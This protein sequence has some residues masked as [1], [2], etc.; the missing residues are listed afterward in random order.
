MTKIQIKQHGEVI[1]WFI[2]NSEKGVYWKPYKELL[3]DTVPWTRTTAPKWLPNTVYIRNDDDVR[4]N[5]VFAE[6][7]AVVQSLCTQEEPEFKTGEWV[8]FEEGTPFQFTKE[9]KN[10]EVLTRWEPKVGEYYWFWSSA[11]RFPMVAELRK[12][13]AEPLGYLAKSTDIYTGGDYYNRC[14]PF[15][16]TLPVI[17]R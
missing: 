17:L 1:K 14:E 5:M 13:D 8:M 9:V 3:N 2:D 12:G 7:E 11:V 6:N 16:G 4:V 15:F 10:L